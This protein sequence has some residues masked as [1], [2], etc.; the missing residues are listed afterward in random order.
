MPSNDER[1]EVA[2]WLKDVANAVLSDSA[3][4]D[5]LGA[6][7]R[8]LHPSEAPTNHEVLLRLADL[9]EPEERTCRITENYRFACEISGAIYTTRFSCGHFM[10]NSVLI[11]EINY[12]PNCGARVTE[13][14]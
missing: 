6:I 1:R 5:A 4:D 3:H 14:E 11:N 13:G 10:E 12:C 7:V 8:S 2:A 9:I